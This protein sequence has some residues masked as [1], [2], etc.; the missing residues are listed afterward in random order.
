M[1]SNRIPVFCVV[2]VVVASADVAAARRQ[3]K[4]T[5]RRTASGAPSG[6]SATNKGSA[7][8][9]KSNGA[10]LELKRLF[11]RFSWEPSV[12]EVQRKALWCARAGH[13]DVRSWRRRVRLSAVLPEVK[14]GLDRSRK[15]DFSLKME[16]GAPS[17]WS[18]GLDAGYS[19]GLQLRWSLDRLIFDPNEL[20][21]S[22]EAQRLSEL[23]EE[24]LDQA[25]RLYFDRRRLQ[26]LQLIRPARSTRSQV[27]RQL[28][29]DRLTA[30][31]DAMTG[32]WFKRELKRRTRRRKT[33]R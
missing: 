11:S 19:W 6:R 27:L 25:T 31:I 20:K 1:K 16:P 22:R 32:G 33:H 15:T 12:R 18:K 2:A 30:T 21:V 24:V 14:V 5:A 17:V 26:V 23:R 28:A 29:L 13:G 9:K 4:R 8:Q 10:K 3:R 7:G